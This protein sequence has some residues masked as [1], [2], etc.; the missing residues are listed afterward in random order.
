[1]EYDADQMKE[2]RRAASKAIRRELP[3]REKFIRTRD[4]LEPEV[5]ESYAWWNDKSSSESQNA[6]MA[7]R[8]NPWLANTPNYK[9]IVGD[10]LAGQLLRMNRGKKPEQKKAV[11]K[12]PDQPT[13]PASQPAPVDPTAARSAAAMEAFQSSPGVEELTKVFAAQEKL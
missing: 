10:A 8:Q 3:D 9:L 11:P 1:M 5:Q 6:V 4:S 12:A 13:T 7:I 2:F